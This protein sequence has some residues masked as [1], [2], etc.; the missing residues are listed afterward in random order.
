MLQRFGTLLDVQDQNVPDQLVYDCFGYLETFRLFPIATAIERTVSGKLIDACHRALCTA[1]GPPTL[2]DRLVVEDALKGLIGKYHLTSFDNAMWTS[3]CHASPR[4]AT[5]VAFWDTCSYLLESSSFNIE[6]SH[7]HI[8]TLLMELI[9]NLASPCDAM[10][11]VALGTLEGLSR[12]NGSDVPDLLKT[13]VQIEHTPISLQSARAISMQIRRLGQVYKETIPD[14]PLGKAIPIYCFG[15]LHIGL[16]QVWEDACDAL[17]EMSTIRHAEEAIADMALKWIIHSDAEEDPENVFHNSTPSGAFKLEEQTTEGSRGPSSLSYDCTYLMD[18][19]SKARSAFIDLGE[20]D[21]ILRENFH[22]RHLEPQA[23][24]L[25]CRSRALKVL[26]RIPQ[27]AER[28]SRLFVPILL[29]SVHVD[30][31]EGVQERVHEAETLH[32]QVENAIGGKWTHRDHKSLWALFAK[33]NNPR[34]LYKSEAVF[35]ALLELLSNGDS[36]VQKTALEAILAWKI[37]VVNR[38]SEHLNKMLDDASFREEITVFMDTD[39][40]TNAYLDE[41]G[42]QLM[43]VLLR[44]LYGKATA[45]AG[46]VHGKKGQQTKRKAVLTALPRLGE[47]GI[48]MFLNIAL[49]PLQGLELIVD[50]SL[51]EDALSQELL[52]Q[53]KQL[54]LLNMLK[55]MLLTI[56]KQVSSYATLI[57]NAVLYCMVRASRDTASKPAELEEDPEEEKTQSSLQKSIRQAGYSCIN[58]LFERIQSPDW[59]SYASVIVREL[60]EPRLGKLSIET[61]QSVSGMLRLFS[62]WCCS[63]SS[64]RY[65]VDFGVPI[66]EHVAG[67]LTVPSAQPEVKLFVLNDILAKLIK[68]AQET[69]SDTDIC[70]RDEATEVG[71]RVVRNNVNHFLTH[72]GRLLKQNPS[73][74]LLEA[75]VQAVAQLASLVSDARDCKLMIETSLQLVKQPPKRVNVHTKGQLLSI[76]NRFAD[77]MDLTDEEELCNESLAV[78]ASLF[79]F[80]KDRAN[81]HMICEI[82]RKFARQDSAILESVS[83]VEDLNAFSTARL[84]E[85]DFERRLRAYNDIADRGYKIFTVKQWRPILFNLLYFINDDIELTIRSSASYTLRR[86][87]DAAAGESSKGE[88][89]FDVLIVT[90]ILPALASGVRAESELVRAE[91]LAVMAHLVRRFPDWPAV[92]DMHV[93]LVGEDDEASF[94]TNIL[95]IQNHRRSRALRRLSGEAKLGKLGSKN[96]SSFFIPLIEHFIFAKPE[97]GG[98]NNLSPEAVNTL[99]TL[100]EW[101]DWQDFRKLFIKY[102]SLLRKGPEMEKTAIKLLGAMTQA[103]S[104]ANDARTLD[105]A[106]AADQA[107][108]TQASDGSTTPAPVRSNLVKTIPEQDQLVNDLLKVF[109]PPLTSYVHLKDEATVGFRAQIATSV[110]RVLRLLPQAEFSHRLHAIMVDVCHILR[111]RSQE[112]RDIV[113]ATLAEI[114]SII[115]PRYFGVILKELR[116][117]LQRGYQL[118]VLSFTLHSLLVSVTPIFQR[119]TIDYCLSDSVSIIMDDIF[120]ATGREKDAEEY[121]SK[122]KEVKSRKSYDSMELLAKMSS[123]HHLINLVKPIKALLAEELDVRALQKI[124]ELLRRLGLGILRTEDI[125]GQ[126]V[127]VFCYELIQEVH[128]IENRASKRSTAEDSTAKR[129]LVDLKGA[130]RPSQSLGS[131]SLVYKLRRFALDIIR[132][133]LAKVPTLRTPSKLAGFLPAIGDSLAHEQQEVQLSS[134]RLLTSIVGLDLPELNRNSPVYLSDAVR[135]IKG[136]PSIDTEIAHASFKLIATILRERRDLSVSDSDMA[137]LLS[138]VKPDL[139]QPDRQG[140]IF[141]F[142]RATLNRKVMVP[143]IYDV[144]DTVASM[145]VTN[146]TRTARDLARGTYFQFLMEYP[147]SRVRLSKQLAFLVKNLDYQYVEGRQ[148]VMEALYL[149]ITKMDK[150][151]VQD[152]LETLYAPLVLAVINDAA[153]ECREMAASLV[154]AIFHRADSDR[155]KSFTAL[156][157]TWSEQTDNAELRRGALQ[158]WAL[159]FEAKEPSAKDVLF[160]CGCIKEILSDAKRGEGATD[161]ELVYVAL[162]SFGTICKMSKEVAFS[163]SSLPL[164]SG[165]RALL[166]YPHAWVKLSAARLIGSHLADL[167]AASS[168]DIQALPLQ[169][170]G[171]SELQEHDLIQIAKDSL[172]VLRMPNL[173]K[174]LANQTV[175]NLL[176]ITRCFSA[177]DTRLPP[178]NSDVNTSSDESSGKDEVQTVKQKSRKAVGGGGR[179][180]VHYVFQQLSQALR[181]DLF[182]G[183]GQY[184]SSKSASL[185]L[186]AALCNALPTS[187]IAPALDAIV[188]SLQNLSDPNVS[189]PHLQSQELMDDYQKLTETTQE[190]MSLLQEKLGTTEYVRVFQRVKDT[191]NEI[192]DERRVKRKIFAVELP[193]K[194]EERKRR[195][196]EATRKKRKERA[197]EARGKRRGW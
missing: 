107:L 9:P 12:R 127:L 24:T 32:D 103:L 162:Q 182:D 17:K 132:M 77:L 108:T 10:R 50:G 16:A 79:N 80:F 128:N 64:I 165:V 138:R 129:Y 195:K 25:V 8:E 180:A 191:R 151:M 74:E 54:G 84:D 89:G 76:L 22:M 4:F 73:K 90:T 153:S 187:S 146:Q 1:D 155:F 172:R 83:L 28:R 70:S 149:L 197:V 131:K 117:A 123:L 29:A 51:N 3:V 134:I 101:I 52:T 63:L 120:G 23:I 99:N 186:M 125:E 158:V 47:R 48:A 31:E 60:I 114:T 177:S 68:T 122:M 160:V 104:R 11:K 192:R 143:E 100:S 109:L 142:L 21:I 156:L 112:S 169:G 164:W 141:N 118:H 106:S 157:R 140:V 184:L 26:H 110:V 20:P 130:K 178:L 88:D 194:F 55:D 87:I 121:I 42:S 92:S 173:S 166:N 119:G 45:R 19:A 163:A 86:F 188:L 66:L 174:D 96:I 82:L 39:D 150:D 5:S 111:S 71:D 171:E 43:A 85:P 148:S 145:M 30:A 139:E 81:R 135:V 62:T 37:P 65:F 124:D 27:V 59:P 189:A 57:A 133:L 46:S 159:C 161:W 176:F 34:V 168:D 91:Y 152:I 36:E 147:Q 98:A 13:A 183:S 193:E 6:W 116:S 185:Q 175:K 154:K 167:A 179:T 97:E 126:D 170:S 67:C 115:G 102:E 15:L 56:G 38:Y 196:H 7:S 2:R 35:S 78:V 113:R 72:I 95:H 58:L 40:N 49:G 105:V 136:A 93:L 75:G 137:Y 18:I 61:A 190:T 181:H 33:F 53:R 144:L 94:F 69:S 14:G 41:H 44:L